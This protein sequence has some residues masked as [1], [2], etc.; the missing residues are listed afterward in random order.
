MG[1]LVRLGT[2]VCVLM[3]FQVFGR[4]K[5]LSAPVKLALKGLQLIGGV[6]GDHV[7]P[8]PL[9]CSGVATLLALYSSVCFDIM[10]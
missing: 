5:S 8:E 7:P 9:F 10:G 3:V 6:L 1:A 4:S 2:S